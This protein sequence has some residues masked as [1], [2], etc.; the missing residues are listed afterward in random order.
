MYRHK[1]SRDVRARLWN[2]RLVFC[3]LRS[4]RIPAGQLRLMFGFQ[5]LYRVDFHLVFAPAA[6]TILHEAA[7]KPRF[8]ERVTKITENRPAEGLNFSSPEETLDF[9]PK[10]FSPGFAEGIGKLQL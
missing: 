8:F 4:S 10:T 7:G 1:A 3:Q 5:P 6:K 2:K 9:Q